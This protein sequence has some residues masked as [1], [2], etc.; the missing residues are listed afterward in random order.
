M[1][2]KLGLKKP[3]LFYSAE[4]SAQAHSVLVLA[5]KKT[6]KLISWRSTP[7]I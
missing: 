5:Q 1:L 6:G 3:F 2:T 7:D 4:A